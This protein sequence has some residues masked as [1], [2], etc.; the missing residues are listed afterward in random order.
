MEKSLTDRKNDTRA[1]IAEISREIAH[2]AAH[3]LAG[4]AFISL[5]CR[6]D[7]NVLILAII[8]SLLPDADTWLGLAHRTASHSLAAIAFIGLLGY[9][10]GGQV[11]DISISVIAFSSHIAVD[12]LHG[13]GI[14]LLWPSRRFFS[15]SQISP[16]W[17]AGASTMLLLAL[18]RG[19]ATP[20]LAPTPPLTATPTRTSTPTCTLTPTATLTP[21]R[22]P[23]PTETPD[24][25]RMEELRLQAQKAADE[26]EFICRA[27]GNNHPKC[28]AAR[29][30][31]E[32]QRAQYCR[33]A[34]CPTPTPT[35][36]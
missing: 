28:R 15:I 22:T 36:P 11:R 24:Y 26:A 9:A 7:D 25:W 14:Q 3:V 1:Y 23:M 21:T 10:S 4:L 5:W 33:L 8:F 19:P 34:N 17:I 12:L 2:Y 27:Y 35:L 30:D 20:P 6:I 16:A 29:Y 13:L 18:A 31:A 32:I